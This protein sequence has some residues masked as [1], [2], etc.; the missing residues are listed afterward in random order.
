MAWL[1]R[2]YGRRP[3]GGR[4]GETSERGEET[5]ARTREEREKGNGGAGDLSLS[6]SSPLSRYARSFLLALAYFTP[7]SLPFGRLPRTQA[8]ETL[9]LINFHC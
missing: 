4:G 9:I 2:G 7:L 5:T 1:W 8:N 3:R 6:L